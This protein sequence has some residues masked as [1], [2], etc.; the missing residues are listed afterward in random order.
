MTEPERVVAVNAL[1]EVLGMP[2]PAA[3]RLSPSY[4]QH[5]TEL[6]GDGF[7]LLVNTQT[8]PP[9]QRCA[10]GA[11]CSHEPSGGVA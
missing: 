3:K 6:S 7:R 1:A 10:C 11:V 4:W 9:A 2:A 5:E 8:D